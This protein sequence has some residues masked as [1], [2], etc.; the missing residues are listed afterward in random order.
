MY[1]CPNELEWSR[2]GITASRKVGNAV[3]RNRWKRRIR[4]IF[5]R[6]KRDIPVGYDF[7][8]IVKRPRKS[9]PG[10]DT[11]REPHFQDLRNELVELM[12]QA[13]SS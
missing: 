1:A 5:R 12:G 4:E 10:D 11:E 2:I 7:V 6:N 13:V 9:D 3:R 8:V